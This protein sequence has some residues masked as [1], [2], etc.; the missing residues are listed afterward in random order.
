MAAVFLGVGLLAGWMWGT[1][2]YPQVAAVKIAGQG[3]SH[4][5]PGGWSP[6]LEIVGRIT[7]EFDCR[8]ADPDGGR[9]DRA[10]IPLGRKF[11]LASG[12]LEITYNT[13]ARVILEGPA[14][15]EVDSAS[16]GFLSLGKLT[17]RVETRA[18]GGGRRAEG[19][20]SGRWAVGS[21]SEIQNPKSEIPIPPS[22][23]RLPPSNQGS[24]GERTA[25][26][27]LS[28]QQRV[29]TT[30]LAPRPCGYRKSEISNSQSLIPNP[31]FS[32]R[33]P[34]AVVTDLGTEFGVEVDRLGGSRAHVFRGRIELRYSD[35]SN[36]DGAEVCLGE[37][38]SARIEGGANRA[39]TVSRE[40]GQPAPFVRQM[41]TR[42][43]IKLYSTGVGLKPGDHDPHWQLVA[44]SNLPNFKPRPAVV[45]VDNSLYLTNDPARSQWISAAAGMVWFPNQVT[46]TFRTT[47]EL[48]G[49][50]RFGGPAVRAPGR[51]LCQC[52]P[53]K[54]PGRGLP[55]TP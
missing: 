19:V 11:S 36:A 18:E 41:P 44:V 13:G 15:Y 42:T 53:A 37:N 40:A 22:A 7:G 38:E 32:V 26:L 28:N 6:T 46:Y 17:A 21:K 2:H 4:A 16:S 29:P 49:G 54:Q 1:S 8:Y 24:K 25:N 5:L 10:G 20:G 48:A 47:F 23:L 14:T 34:S 33:T 51:R 52:H 9:F 50:S 12:L 27:A 39:V 31:L 30:S 45:R 43:P 35:G 55:P 3:K